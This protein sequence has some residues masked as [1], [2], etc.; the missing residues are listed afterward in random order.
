MF[1]T[2]QNTPIEIDLVQQA[3]STGW[4]IEGDIAIHEV[5]NDGHIYLTSYPLE[6][7]KTYEVTYTVLTLSGG[8]IRAWAGDTPSSAIITTTGSKT[9]TLVASGENPKFHFYSNA[10]ARVKLFNIR[11]TATNTNLKQRNSI[12]WSEQDNKWKTFLTYNPDSAFSLFTNLYSSKNGQSFVH[13][14]NGTSRNFFYGTQYKSFIKLV[15]NAQP[16]QTK[17]FH[18]IAIQGNRLMV[19]TED[20]IETSLGQISELIDTD[21]LRDTLDDGVTQVNVYSKEGVYSASFLKDK[22]DGGI[23][24]GADLKGNWISI[25]LV[26]EETGI[27][28][29]FTISVHSTLS[30]I[31]VR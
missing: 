20:G 29:M 23:I 13:K 11:D 26:T 17:T 30:K 25:D 4:N 18:S 16:Q 14:P 7:G 19:T 9:D 27:L 28:K 15:A 6:E 10:N 8:N 3:K 5:C 21:F 2:L 1:T 22:N 24:N 31:G 12:V